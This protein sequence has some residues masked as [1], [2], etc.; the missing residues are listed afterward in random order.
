MGIG[1]YGVL[2]LGFDDGAD[3]MQEVTKA[4]RLLYLQPYSETNAKIKTWEEDQGDERYG[5]PKTYSIT[6]ASA[7][8]LSKASVAVHHSRVIHVAE[9]TTENDIYGTPRL[10]AVF[11]RLQNLELVIGGSAE[12][13]WRGA[14]PGYAFKEQKDYELDTQAM[15]DLQDELELYM[16]DLQRYLRLKG[17]DLEEL[18]MQVASPKDHVE[19]ILDLISGATDIPKRILI[20]SERGELASSQD[21]KNWA[22]RIDERRK[23]FAEPMILR[24]L[25][26]RLIRLE[27]IARPRNDS[28][29]VEWPPIVVPSEKDEAEVG[30]AKAEAL[31]KYVSGIGAEQILPP[32]LFLRLILGLDEDQIKEA[33]ELLEGMARG[34]E[35]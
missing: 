23:D 19:V 6:L 14:F 32:E 35:R 20:G 2:L 27:V 24:P 28:Y 26:D 25:I 18:A 13:F 22:T 12:M 21:E 11:N 3:F 10:K 31:N 34:E 7:N 4:G 15:S 5:Q 9:G 29:S 17:V 30:K 16:H 33:E 8:K 1:Q